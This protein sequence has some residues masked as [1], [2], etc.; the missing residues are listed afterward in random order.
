MRTL[1]CLWALALGSGCTVAPPIV[2][3][4]DAIPSLGDGKADTGYYSNGAVELDGI[5]RGTLRASADLD[6]ASLAALALRQVKFAKT[7]LYRGGLH[8]NLVATDVELG[9]RWSNDDGTID[10]AYTARGEALVTNDGLALTGFTDASEMVG[11]TSTIDVPADPDRL[12]A[13]IGTACAGQDPDSKL[14]DA[15]YF[16][17]WEP[18]Q[19]GCAEAVERTTLTYEIDSVPER[20]T[21]YPELDR[22]AEDQEITVVSMY[23]AAENASDRYD[24]G[25]EEAEHFVEQ[26][27]ERGFTHVGAADGASRGKRYQRERSGLREIVDV[28]FPSE[29]S[30]SFEDEAHLIRSHE[31]VIY[32]GHARAGTKRGL[33][34]SETF[35]SDYQVIALFS[36]WGYDYYAKQALDAK[37][38]VNGDPWALIDV[39]AGTEYGVFGD[40]YSAP[41][42][43]NLL[44]AVERH[45]SGGDTRPYS[46]SNLLDMLNTLSRYQDGS[47]RRQ[48]FGAGGVTTNTY[49]PA[50]DGRA[51][52]DDLAEGAIYRRVDGGGP[53]RTS[54]THAGCGGYVHLFTP[55]L[56]FR[57]F[58]R[59]DET[60]RILA[61]PVDD[62]TDLGLLIVHP[63]GNTT[64]VEVDADTPGAV[65]DLA[66][67]PGEH[68]VY[69]SAAAENVVVP[70]YLAVTTDRSFAPGDIQY[71][72]Q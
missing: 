5:Y 53:R 41:F 54:D 66:A 2:G 19:A 33:A 44:E 24:P 18:D 21:T 27:T 61:S 12:F 1:A 10:V 25:N 64:C 47:H 15:T 45:A 60:I 14:S 48:V 40:H 37:A 67:R 51:T 31:I 70:A 71:Y 65:F 7:T 56:R 3:P 72:A 38:A 13:R 55:S 42:L 8:P 63:D 57:L 68:K 26:L 43:I 49:W 28:I 20:R 9:D 32:N 30:E 39:V 17:Y 29:L 36:C 69:V 4:S 16:S 46:W 11:S 50:L 52:F 59:D 22:L 23:G 34:A 6:G 62:E 35:S 58:G